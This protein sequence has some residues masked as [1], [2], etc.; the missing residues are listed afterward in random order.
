MAETTLKASSLGVI[1]V[2]A[3]GSVMMAPALGIYANLGLIS[4]SS[5]IAA[6][7]VFL[8]SLLCTL[9]TAVSYALIAR[10]IPSAGSAYTWLS[11]AVNPWV[12]TWMG[13]LLIATYL[14]CVILQP[15]LFGL[16]FSD[17]LSSLLHFQAGYGTWLVGVLVS[18][19]IVASFVYPG[20][21]IAAK[22]SLIMT[23]L[24]ATVVGALS[25]TIAIVLLRKGEIHL[26]PFNPL[27]SL[28][29][30]DGFSRALVFALLSFVGFGVIATAAEET[31]SPREVIPRAMILACVLLGL[32][33]AVTSWFFVLTIPQQAWG[34]YATQGI[35][36]IAIIARMYWSGA[37]VLV[38]LTAITAVLGVYLASVVGYSRVAFAMG[39]DG[40]LPAFLGKLH[41]KYRTPWNAQHIAF[42]LTLV[43]VPIWGRWV[44]TY[45]SYDWWGSAVVFFSM[46]SNILVSIC[47][48]I[49]F[50]RFR[51]NSAN[52]FLHGLV[53]FFG[54][55][56]SLL[57][58]Y[59]AFGPELWRLGWKKGQS[60]IVFC[61][62]TVLLSAF[63][64][65]LLRRSEKRD[66]KVDA[67]KIYGNHL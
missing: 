20:V 49:Y 34:E 21:E 64:T 4:A 51:R 43:I 62:L 16:F 37:S 48:T 25:V 12:G 33:W 44:G 65:A 39:R 11:D 6:P 13:V 52:L 15:I 10:E 59:F 47:C 66:F 61:L 29:G 14:F 5:G 3:L 8:I 67:E 55:L 23:I 17:L 53:P 41:P 54:I 35:N 32:F 19:A 36:P 56:T 1:S 18:T 42:V 38:I 45:L 58:L 22:T 31:H 27:L 28:G 60:V 9:P 57:P 46:I 63:Y 30:V 50:Y 7:A 40:A 24:E 26:A 2:A